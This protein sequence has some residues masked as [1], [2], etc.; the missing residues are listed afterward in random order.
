VRSEYT[1]RLERLTA[2]SCRKLVQPG[3]DARDLDGGLVRG[4]EFVVASGDGAVVLESADGELDDDDSE[5]RRQV[6][7]PGSSR[8]SVP[9]SLG[10][11]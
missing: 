4:G 3:G 1:E 10:D 6:E 9:G 5:D 7:M 8:G 2:R 11:L